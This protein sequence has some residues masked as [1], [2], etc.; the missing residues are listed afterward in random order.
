MQ[1]QRHAKGY[2]QNPCWSGDNISSTPDFKGNLEQNR[3]QKA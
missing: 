3:Q 1:M 2:A